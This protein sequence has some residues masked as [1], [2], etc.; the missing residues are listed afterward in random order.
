MTHPIVLPTRI[1]TERLLLRLYVHEDLAQFHAYVSDPATMEFE[2]TCSGS[3]D[4]SRDILA[5]RVSNPE[6][7]A[8]ELLG[9][10][11]L[12]GNLYL[13]HG[14]EETRTLGYV[15]KRSVW[16]SG[17]ATEACQGLIKENWAAGIPRVE[18]FCDPQNPRSWRLLERLGFE[19]FAHLKQDVYFH[20]DQDGEP[21]W[22]DTYRYGINNPAL[23]KIG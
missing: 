21:I 18:A 11:D 5:G 3:I 1:S 9:S 13:G 22:K 19:R 20:V 2:R 7:Y 6:F 8:V 16:G 14:G 12:L 23:P 15:F 17:Y 10:G 4:Q